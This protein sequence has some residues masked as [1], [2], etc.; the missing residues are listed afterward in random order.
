MEQ[1]PSQ[2]A[3]AGQKAKDA[4]L[5]KD[6]PT[7][8]AEAPADKEGK[9]FFDAD[10]QVPEWPHYDDP[11][12]QKDDIKK[13][14]A[15]VTKQVD[16]WQSLFQE[17]QKQENDTDNFVGLTEFEKKQKEVDLTHGSSVTKIKREIFEDR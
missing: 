4:D 13:E 9:E 17:A 15:E 10:L 6:D 11:I 16:K 1:G 8:L 7:Q 12:S 3:Q 5:Y 2:L 14:L